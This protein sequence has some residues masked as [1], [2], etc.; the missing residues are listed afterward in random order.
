MNNIKNKLLL[1][2]LLLANI[3]VVSLIINTISKGRINEN[4]NVL[5]ESFNTDNLPSFTVNDLAKYS[6]DDISRPIYI[7]FEGKV[8]DVTTGHNY[9]DI[10]GPYHFLAG[11]DSTEILLLVGGDIIKSKYPVIGYIK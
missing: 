3:I 11:K 2:I 8:Y 4:S 9:Y 10:N 5:A 1:L 7:G 6:G